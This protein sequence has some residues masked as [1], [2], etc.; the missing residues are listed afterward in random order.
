MVRL[1]EHLLSASEFAKILFGPH[2]DIGIA[3]FV[4]HEEYDEDLWIHD[5]AMIYLERDVLFT[6]D[7][8]DQKKVCYFRQK[9]FAFFCRPYLSN[10][11]TN[12]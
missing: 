7:S 1:G 9:N 12:E 11:L 6:G 3:R 10:L 8:I 5:I 2:E 4:I